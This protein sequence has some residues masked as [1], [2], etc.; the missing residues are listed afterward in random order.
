M[1][2]LQQRRWDYHQR[3]NLWINERRTTTPPWSIN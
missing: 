2:N 3:K 1:N